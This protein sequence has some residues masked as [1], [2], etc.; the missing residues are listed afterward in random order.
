MRMRTRIVVALAVAVVMAVAGFAAWELGVPAY[1]RSQGVPAVS[2]QET[3][4]L[5][6]QVYD[7]PEYVH[8][9]DRYGPPGPVALVFRGRQ[10]REGFGSTVRDPWYAVSSR[11]GS[12]ARLSVPTLDESVDRVWLSPQGTRL[13]WWTGSG[14]SLY[15]TMT[16]ALD[17]DLVPPVRGGDAPALVWSPDA[18]RVA[19]GS[20]P[21]R[22]LDTGSGVVRGLALRSRRPGV[23]P[24]W[25]ADGRWVTLAGPRGIVG[26]DPGT[27]ARRRVAARVGG[28]SGAEWNGA[29]DLAGVHRTDDRVNV[30]RVVRARAL[31]ERHGRPARAPRVFDASPRAFSLQSLWG[32]A[33]GREVVLA[34]LLAESGGLEQA[35]TVS[36]GSASGTPTPYT[37][38]PSRGDNW[39]GLQTVSLATD[40]LRRPSEPFEKPAVPWAPVAKLMLCLL[41]A[42]FPTVYYL[43]ARRPRSR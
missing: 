31:T 21:V 18:T 35:V 3:L 28:V 19:F 9:T 20:R 25:T 15:D 39:A 4:S 1:Q 26:V 23:T 36:L 27:G 5:P 41:L 24:S 30:L 42:V 12:Y 11:D 13:A 22:V 34:G 29:G 38:L 37:V 40:L 10:A 32:W 2:A 7:A 17:T 33:G 8:P 6:E 43:V 16:G 14:I